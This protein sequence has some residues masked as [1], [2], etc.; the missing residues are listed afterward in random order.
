MVSHGGRSILLERCEVM[1]TARG[2]IAV[3]TGGA[4]AIGTAIT[5][6]LRETGHRTVVLDRSGDVAC[7]LSSETSTR[8][9]AATVLERYGRCDVFVHCAAAFDQVTIA[10]FDA[11]TWRHVQA[12]NVESALWLVQAFTPGMA[13]RGF[14]RIVFITSDTFWAPPLPALLAY[15]ASKGALL[16]VMRTLAVTLGTDGIAV[17]AVAPGLTETAASRVVNTDE[18][19]DATVGRQALKRR[20]TP[21]DTAAAV[22]YLASEGAAAMTGQV[23]CADGGLIMR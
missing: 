14:G 12:V 1:T 9:A 13:E 15:V 4:G 23:L 18:Q 19:F 3:V 20:L 17:S 2:R 11:A 7:D 10:D 8:A 5:K 6:A 16:G 21:G 22:A